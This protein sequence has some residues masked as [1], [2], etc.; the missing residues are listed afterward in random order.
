MVSVS[1]PEKEINNDF[2]ESENIIIEDKDK[3]HNKTSESS[4]DKQEINVPPESTQYNKE[5]QYLD[6]MNRLRQK[7]VP[8][9]LSKDKEVIIHKLFIQ[10]TC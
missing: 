7:K 10:L 1:P 9:L 6:F 4:D 2:T 5:K 3:Q 8:K